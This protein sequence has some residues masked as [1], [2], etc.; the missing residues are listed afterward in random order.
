MKKKKAVT[1]KKKTPKKNKTPIKK[2]L[3][4]AVA[5]PQL[6]VVSEASKT[7]L[8]AYELVSCQYVTAV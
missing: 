2:K 7:S 4:K 6:S 1:K 8:P 5:A 3:M